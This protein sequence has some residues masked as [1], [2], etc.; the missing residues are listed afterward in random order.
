MKQ[1]NSVH[2]FLWNHWQDQD[3]ICV[4]VWALHVWNVAKALGQILRWFAAERAWL[5]GRPGL[6]E[7]QEPRE[8]SLGCSLAPSAPSACGAGGLLSF[9]GWGVVILQQWKR[10]RTVSPSGES[11]EEILTEASKVLER[12]ERPNV[13]VFQWQKDWWPE[14][15]D[16]KDIDKSTRRW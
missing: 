2:A 1:K 13:E 14:D 9:Q 10:A 8:N 4:N 3:L 5:R 16:L 6:E 11:R 12:F 15:R 7:A